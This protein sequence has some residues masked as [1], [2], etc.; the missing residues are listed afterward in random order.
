MQV[1]ERVGERPR[2]RGDL[3]RRKRA[4]TQPILQRAS[5]EHLDDQHRHRAERLEPEHDRDA[6]VLQR[7]HQ[8]CLVLHPRDLVGTDLGQRFQRDGSL[9]GF[10][11]R[12]VDH[13]HAAA[14]EAPQQREAAE[15]RRQ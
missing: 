9:Q 2:E 12:L 11:A 4:G 6:G 3:R 15:T 8:A 7:R 10:V 13:A 1:V 5:R 14:A